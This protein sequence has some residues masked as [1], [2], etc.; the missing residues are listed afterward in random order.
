MN[1]PHL[2]AALAD[3]DNTLVELLNLNGNLHVVTHNGRVG[4]SKWDPSRRP[5]RRRST[6]ATC[7]AAPAAD[8]PPASPRPAL[9][10]KPHCMAT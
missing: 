2:L 9:G 8:N 10:S 5:P 4:V 3:R 6:P 1:V 7:S